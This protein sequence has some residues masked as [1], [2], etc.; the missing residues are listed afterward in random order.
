MP[1]ASDG[2]FPRDSRDTAHAVPAPDGSPAPLLR[3][4]SHGRGWL[5][6]GGRNRGSGRHKRAFLQRIEELIM[7]DE[8]FEAVRAILHNPKSP[9]F[10]FLWRVLASYYAGKPPNDTRLDVTVRPRPNMAEARRR[11]EEKLSAMEQRMALADQFEADLNNGAHHD[12]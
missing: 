2:L 8:T 4:P 5:K 9:Q 11:I 6:V 7:A 12:A 10:V 1:N 3:R